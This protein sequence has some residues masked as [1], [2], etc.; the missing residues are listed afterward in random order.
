M[1]KK[2]EQAESLKAQSEYL[3]AIKIYEQIQKYA[4][5]KYT[6][7][8]KLAIEELELAYKTRQQK[9]MNKYGKKLIDAFYGEVVKEKYDRAKTVYENYMQYRGL[10]LKTESFRRRLK[11]LKKL[12]QSIK[13]GINTSKIKKWS[14]EKLQEELF[15]KNIIKNSKIKAEADWVFA[16][17]CFKYF[18]FNKARQ[19]FE[20]VDDLDESEFI[21]KYYMVKI[22]RYIKEDNA[23]RS[24]SSLKKLEKKIVKTSQRSS[25]EIYDKIEDDYRRFS[26]T[27]SYK[28]YKNFVG[29]I[30]Y[31]VWKNYA[32]KNAF[33]LYFKKEFSE[34]PSVSNSYAFKIR[35]SFEK[36][37]E[38]KDFYFYKNKENPISLKVKDGLKVSFESKVGLFEMIWKGYLSQSSIVMN[39]RLIDE[40]PA[41]IGIFFYKKLKDFQKLDK[42]LCLTHFDLYKMLYVEMRHKAGKI[43]NKLEEKFKKGSKKANICFTQG[44]PRTLRYRKSQLSENI[45]KFETRD[46]YKLVGEANIQKVVFRI[47]REKK[48]YMK[49]KKEISRGYSGI[50]SNSPFII[51]SIEIEG[52]LHPDF[53]KKIQK[54][55]VKRFLSKFDK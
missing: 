28:K 29:K 9:H 8:I 15:Y 36:K 55:I 23:K 6:E 10:H 27:K 12:V 22:D 43:D 3:K 32:L 25:I 13:T 2:I 21:D 42:F 24:L 26:K 35:Y 52:K 40:S 41:N 47:N 20:S 53:A 7:E 1:P 14:R 31:K 16:I 34:Y 11:H 17:I 51:D 44:N 33:H 38:L 48:L 19:F 50:Y 30:R 18:A 4:I 49:N 5:G 54:N 46:S 37:N 45:T 39:I